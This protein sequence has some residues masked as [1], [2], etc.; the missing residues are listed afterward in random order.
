[1]E[2]QRGREA[3]FRLANKAGSHSRSD[4][5]EIRNA[6]SPDGEKAVI[7]LYDD[8]GFFGSTA[9]DFANELRDVTA[10]LIEVRIASAGGDMWDGIAIYNSLRSHPSRVVTQVDSMAASIASVIVQA[11]DHRVMLEH[12]Q[13]LI[14]EAWGVAI[15]TGAEMR[16]LA[17][18]LD[19]QSDI[20]AG[21]Y[22][23]AS[24][25][26]RSKA[27]FRN[28]MSTG[29]ANLGSLFTDQETVDIGLADEVVKPA[30]QK[31]SAAVTEPVKASVDFSDLFN[32]DP[33][34]FDWSTTPKTK[35]SV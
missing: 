16:E 18:L 7:Y 17:D 5:F 20:I 4:W 8:I 13:M 30:K 23:Q 9:Q 21:I 15:G 32:L 14:H 26:G 28:L 33:D 22:A 25:D 1:M 10:P 3:V 35:E 11:G 2:F 27:K 24:G 31:A 6:A 29:E 34:E 12:S 19:G